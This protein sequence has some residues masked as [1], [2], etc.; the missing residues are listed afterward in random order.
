MFFSVH[1]GRCKKKKSEDNTLAS[2]LIISRLF[3]AKNF[4]EN[5]YTE[6]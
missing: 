3:F 4:F 6:I 5:V 2:A 1:P